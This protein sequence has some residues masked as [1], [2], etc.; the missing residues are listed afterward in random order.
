MK[1][2]EDQMILL[3][4][5]VNTLYDISNQCELD[6]G[7][8]DFINEVVPKYNLSP[9]S[10]EDLAS[11]WECAIGDAKAQNKRDYK[12]ESQLVPFLYEIAEYNAETSDT[13]FTFESYGQMVSDPFHDETLRDEVHPFKYYDPEKLKALVVKWITK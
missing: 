2:T 11:Q 3:V 5:L 1:V 7:F 9:H 6:T 10:L 8:C 4:Q 13:K 12:L